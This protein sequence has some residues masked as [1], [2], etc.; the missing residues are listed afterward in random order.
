MWRN[1]RSEEEIEVCVGSVDEKWL[2]GDRTERI[3]SESL[4]KAGAWHEMLE[5]EDALGRDIAA[6]RAG[7]F[8]WRN[9]V[10]GVT[11]QAVAGKKWVEDTQ[12][13]LAIPE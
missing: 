4:A 6:P 2:I 12:R 1:A 11:D 10:K 13:G 5:Q 8:F 9:A 7:N 3:T